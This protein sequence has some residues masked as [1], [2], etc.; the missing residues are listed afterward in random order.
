MAGVPFK[1]YLPSR[2]VKLGV[3]AQSL[4]H[5]HTILKDKLDFAESEVSLEDGTLICN[6]EYFELLEP[7]TTL[8]VQQSESTSKMFEL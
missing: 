1:L 4:K 6:E 7:Q 2:Q 8:V 5:L 3:V